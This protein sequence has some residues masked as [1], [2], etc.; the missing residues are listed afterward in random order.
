[1][2]ARN[3]PETAKSTRFFVYW[4]EGPDAHTP[5]NLVRILQM[6]WD[7]LRTGRAQRWA[8]FSIQMDVPPGTAHPEREIADAV[9][10]LLKGR[11]A[12]RED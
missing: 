10:W 1:M 6:G 4:F 5:H 12:G 3:A 2:Y 7:R 8:Y 9:A 11:T